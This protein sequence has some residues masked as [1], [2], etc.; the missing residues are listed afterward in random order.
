M[1]DLLGAMFQL[2]ACYPS[3][4]HGE[5]FKQ[6]PD[7]VGRVDLLHLHLGVHVAVIHKVHVR[8]FHLRHKDGHTDL[9]TCGLLIRRVVRLSKLH[10]GDAVLV[11]HHSDHVLQG[12]Q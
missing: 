11:R 10:L 2:V 4:V 3:H 8:D 7:V 9:T 1:P 6:F 12:E 5:V